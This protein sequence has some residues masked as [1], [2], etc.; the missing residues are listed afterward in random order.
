MTPQKQKERVDKFIPNGTPRWVRVYDSGEEFND[1]YTVVYTGRYRHNTGGV[2]WYIGMNSYGCGCH[3]EHTRQID[4]KDGFPPAIGRKNHL[5][6]RIKWDDLPEDCKKFALSTY[7]DLWNLNFEYTADYVVFNIR[8]AAEKKGQLSHVPEH[9]TDEDFAFVVTLKNSNSEIVDQYDSMIYYRDK[10][11]SESE[12]AK[13]AKN[14][15]RDVRNGKASNYF[16][17]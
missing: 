3:G 15:V 16:S 9:I 6:K 4:V 11:L 5:G 13:T 7:K 17:L 2:F 1:R 14:I 8:E 10:H 12:C